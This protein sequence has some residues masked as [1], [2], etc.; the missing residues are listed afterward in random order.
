MRATENTE[1]NGT[2][3]SPRRQIGPWGTLSRLALGSVFIYV[4]YQLGIGWD[5]AVIGL[6]GFPAAVMVALA[7]RGPDAPP[8]RLYGP[9]SYCLG[10]L[11]WAVAFIVAPVPTFL[12]AGATQL[13]AAARGYAGCELFAVSNWIRQRDDQIGCAVHTLV[14]QAEARAAG[15]TR[16]DVC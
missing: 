4:A 6:V 14:D 9:D 12:F 16:E 3:V 1:T 5:D 11:V 2:P 7:L 8:L 13:L 15:R 10:F